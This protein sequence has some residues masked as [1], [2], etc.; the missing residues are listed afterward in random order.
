MLLSMSFYVPEKYSLLLKMDWYKDGCYLKHFLGVDRTLSLS[1]SLSLS[2]GELFSES[3][4]SRFE[5]RSI[6]FAK[7]A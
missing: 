2:R 4:E 3:G 5:I 6:I 1:L 7:L